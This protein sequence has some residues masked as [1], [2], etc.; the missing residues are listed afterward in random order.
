MVC[1]RNLSNVR[2]GR[3]GSWKLKMENRVEEYMGQYRKMR[4]GESAIKSSFY[5]RIFIG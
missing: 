2:E 3:N 5:V 4:N 1:Y